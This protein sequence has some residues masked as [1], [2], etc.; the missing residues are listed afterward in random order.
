MTAVIAAQSLLYS[1]NVLKD[2]QN[3][4]FY[5]PWV[6]DISLDGLLTPDTKPDPAFPDLS[7]PEDPTKSIFSSNLIEKL[8]Y[9]YVTG[10][11]EKGNPGSRVPHPA[12]AKQIRLGLALSNL[13]G[14]AYSYPLRVKQPGDDQSFGY[15]RFQDQMTGFFSL[16]GSDRKD[17]LSVWT[18]WRN[19]AVSCGAFP[20]AFR[21]K[22][23]HRLENEYPKY[24]RVPWSVPAQDFAYTDGGVF[25]NE[26]LGLAKNLVDLIDR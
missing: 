1:G 2:P 26:P 20:F 16:D 17:S 14:V 21:V 15:A 18:P 11:Y 3:N 4:P 25:Q 5:N 23:L 24:H 6:A 9:K 7:A 12:A 8:A 10:R 19:V 22:E 13:N